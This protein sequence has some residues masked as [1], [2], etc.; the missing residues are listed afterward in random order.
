[1][2]ITGVGITAIGVTELDKAKMKPAKLFV[3]ALCLA[4]P[5]FAEQGPGVNRVFAGFAY[6]FGGV[7]KA[8]EGDVNGAIADFNRLIQVN[9]KDELAYYNRAL[10]EANKGDFDIAIADFNHAIQLRPTFA[11]AYNDRGSVKA[12]KRDMAG[13]IADF[14]LAIQLSPQFVQAYLNLGSAKANAGDFDSAIADFNHAVRLDA[15]SVEALENLGS[16]KVRSGDFEGAIADYNQAIQLNPKYF[17]AF[18]KRT[19]AKQLEGNFQGAL[20]GLVVLD[21]IA[22]CVDSQD[23]PH[24]YTWLVRARGGQLAEADRELAAYLGTRRNMAV[25]DWISEIG[26]FLLDQISESDFLDDA[27]SSDLEKDR[28]QHCEAWYYVGMKR[29]LAG[30]KK[31]AALYFDKC[32][33]TQEKNFDEYI[34]AQ[35]ELKSLGTTN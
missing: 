1:V 2:G 34:L 27:T 33:G 6:Y 16:A 30:D 14:N 19:L 9:P 7:A 22:R 5:A 11:R 20:S 35:A 8:S 18:E 10:L 12:A 17:A 32:L 3:C 25:A 28:A 4:A 21:E 31:T 15:D 24:L 29:L 13:A 26:R 23:Y